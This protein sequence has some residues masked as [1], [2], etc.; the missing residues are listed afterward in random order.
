MYDDIDQLS[1][2]FAAHEH[3]TPDAADVLVRAKAIA[4]SYQRR[5]WAVRAT[6]G[7]VLGAGLVAGGIAL[8]GRLGHA[9]T[10][11]TVA[12][13]PADGGTPSPS[14]TAASYTDD[15]EWAAYFAAGY[16]YNDAQQL[17]A[18]WHDNSDIGTVKATAGLKLLEGQT[19]P[20]PPSGTPE[21]QAQKAQAEF[22]A[23]GYDS[24]DA[25]TL[26][27][28][29]HET[30]LSHVK[31]QAGQDLLDGRTLPIKPSGESLTQAEGSSTAQKLILTKSEARK[32]ALASSTGS[33]VVV[34]T[35]QDEALQAYFAAGYDYD[36]AVTLSNMW[37]DSN[38]FQVK[39]DAGQ[40]LLDGGS[41]PIPPSGTPEPAAEK[42]QDA[43]FNAGYTYDDAVSLAKIWHETDTSRVKAEAGQKLLDG[44]K[45]PIGP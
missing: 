30:D 40:K 17:A 43:F 21:T 8:P 1:E 9:S 2:T 39:T 35:K 19:L 20:I 11:Q 15:E 7:A 33:T 26:S 23:A 10:G 32:Q 36:D 29:W 45:L 28:R 6:G 12:V 37:H 42:A 41:L 18:L 34:P 44:Q 24:T 16:D 27:Q 38:V 4:R 5:R 22:F 14:A 13:Q 25:V 31:T 3:L